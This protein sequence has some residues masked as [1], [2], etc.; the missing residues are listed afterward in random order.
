MTL[1]GALAV[2]DVIHGGETAQ[3]LCHLRGIG[4]IL[5]LHESVY[6]LGLLIDRH[7]RHRVRQIES[8]PEHLR[9]SLVGKDVVCGR[10]VPRLSLE[11]ER[12]AH[13]GIGI[14]LLLLQALLDIVRLCFPKLIPLLRTHHRKTR[15]V[16]FTVEIERRHDFGKARIALGVREALW[17]VQ[18]GAE[19]LLE[20]FGADLPGIQT[21]GQENEIDHRPVC[22]KIGNTVDAGDGLLIFRRI[23]RGLCPNC[24]LLL[25]SRRAGALHRSNDVVL[26]DL[27]DFSRV[28]SHQGGGQIAF[29]VEVEGACQLQ[30]SIVLEG[31]DVAFGVVDV[32]FEHGLDSR[33]RDVH[34]LEADSSQRKFIHARCRYERLD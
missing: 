21:L 31:I 7:R 18:V 12:K 23:L 34:G 3:Q 26:G 5:D 8:G 27:E 29:C 2:S 16:A 22:E 4:Q 32:A 24:G 15:D 19:D 6:E 28:L 30:I 1:A 25:G 13:A 20:K 14:A 17:I 9:K 11:I 33:R 10:D